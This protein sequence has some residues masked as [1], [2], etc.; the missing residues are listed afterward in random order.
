MAWFDSLSRTP[1]NAKSSRSFIEVFSEFALEISPVYHAAAID[2]NVLL[3][4][5]ILHWDDIALGQC[6]RFTHSLLLRRTLS[7]CSLLGKLAVP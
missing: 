4:T 1:S 7:I 5:S 6:F 2:Y 3:Q